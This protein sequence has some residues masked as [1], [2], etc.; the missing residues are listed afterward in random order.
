M[1]RGLNMLRLAEV[2]RLDVHI[3]FPGIEMAGLKAH[4]PFR[5]RGQ[6]RSSLLQLS[7]PL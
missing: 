6:M 1:H 3:P 4:V 5:G 7:S 2:N